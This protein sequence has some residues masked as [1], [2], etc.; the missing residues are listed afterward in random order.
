[1]KVLARIVCLVLCLPLLATLCACARTPD[2][3]RSSISL[4]GDLSAPLQIQIDNFVHRQPPAVYV[5]PGSNLGYRPTALF[6]PLR[7]MQQMSEAQTFGAMLS[8]QVW[9][10]WLS[11]NV[12]D[13]LEFADEAGPY[14]R[15]RALELAR[16]KGADFVVGG[17]INH[18]LDGGTGGES[19]L[20][21]LLEIHDVRTGTQLW[22]LAQAGMMESRQ[23]HDFY[24]FTVRERNPADPSSFIARSLAWDMGQLVRRWTATAAQNSSAPSTVDKLLGRQAF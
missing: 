24:L 15:K 6:V 11:L 3:S 10:I 2:D 4:T 12:F 9:Q 23:V 7:M 13:T 19:S 18:Y 20:S 14:S 22:S 21:L 5:Q 17:F 1:M 16:A 8:R